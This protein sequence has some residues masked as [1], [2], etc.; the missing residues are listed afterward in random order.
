MV[1]STFLLER[2][3]EATPVISGKKKEKSYK[4]DLK[5]IALSKSTVIL[6]D[7]KVD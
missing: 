6:I 1:D 7:S 2:N 3:A 5:K 4:N